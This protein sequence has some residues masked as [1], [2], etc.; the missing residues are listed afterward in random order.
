MDRNRSGWRPDASERVEG[1]TVREFGPGARIRL[2]FR[3]K[4]VRCRECLKL[5][6]TKANWAYATRLRGEILNAIARG[7][8]RYGDYFPDSK[9]AGIFGHAVSRKTIGELL[10]EHVGRCREAAKRGNMSPGTVRVYAGDAELLK[11]ELGRIRAVD[12]TAGHIKQLIAKQDCTAKT[13]RNRLSLLRVVCDEAL[14]E[15]V[16]NANPFAGLATRRAIKKVAT[17]SDWEV[18]PFSPEER[19]AFLEACPTDEERDMYTFW[20]HTGLRPGELIAFGWDQVDGVHKRARIDKAAAEREEKGPK[21]EAGIRDVELDAQAWA[22]LERQRART[23]LAG[24]RVWRSPKF[25]APWVDDAQLRRSSYRHVMRKAKIRWRNMYQL[26]H[27]YAS[28]HCSAGCNLFWLARQMG[29]ETI[30]MLIRHYGRWIE[31]FKRDAAAAAGGHGM[32]TQKVVP[33]KR[34]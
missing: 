10:D 14:E 5:E 7:T 31:T 30:E 21:T 34:S 22:A 25:E 12:L 26:R 11:D 15:G 1:L 17:K 3:Y 32:G 24:G 6:L 33:L 27:T 9:R 28:T 23:F 29:H 19:A 2:D 13:I 20:L 8:F 18:D 4:G 16:L